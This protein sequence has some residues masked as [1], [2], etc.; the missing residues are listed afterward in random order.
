MM[1][2][3]ATAVV[4]AASL[5]LGGLAHGAPP[6]KSFK[7]SLTDPTTATGSDIKITK[8][9]KVQIKAASGAVTFSLKMNGVLKKVDDTPETSTGHTLSIQL[10]V[11]GVTKTPTFTFD[12]ANG[13][14]S[15]SATLKFPVS[16]SD[17]GTWGS[18]LSPD[19]P[20]E[21]RRIRVIEFST[22][23]DFGVMGVTTQ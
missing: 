8:A 19:T 20:I 5:T 11:N 23:E 10:L 13:R 22:G 1:P 2:K 15:P 9:S 4:L 7:V 18:A 12:L 14:T 16:L 6:A 17:T 21:I 3:A